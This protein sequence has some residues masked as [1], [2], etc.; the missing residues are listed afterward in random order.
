MAQQNPFQQDI[1][2]ET[3]KE[4]GM[5]PE[6]TNIHDHLNLICR[7][8]QKLDKKI[9]VIEESNKALE[10]GATKHFNALYAKV[11]QKQTMQKAKKVRK[12][13]LTSMQKQILDLYKK[14]YKQKE[15]AQKVGCTEPNVSSHVQRM[16]LMGYD[17]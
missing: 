14:G 11:N 17:V 3:I 9:I 1:M 6:S 10:E 13:I 4:D 8:I 5:N 7:C 12:M 2:A 15:I 16:R